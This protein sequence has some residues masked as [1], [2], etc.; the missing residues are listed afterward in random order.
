MCRD[1]NAGRS[2]NVVID[3]S[4]FVMVEQFSY[5]GKTLTGRN[6]IQE[7]I[8]SGLKPGNVCCHSVQNHLSSNFTVQKYKDE[9]TQNCMRCEGRN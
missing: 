6:S 5:L 3:S 4:S 2:H 8:K 7:E 1:Q 9:D